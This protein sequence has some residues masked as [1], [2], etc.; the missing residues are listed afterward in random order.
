MLPISVLQTGFINPLEDVI[1]VPVLFVG[2]V[3]VLVT[4]GHLV[5]ACLDRWTNVELDDDSVDQD[6]GRLIG[7]CENILVITLV[8]AGAYTALGL[9]FAAKSFIRRDDTTSGDTTYY[10]AGTLVNFTYSL[11][12]GVLL[13]MV[14]H[15]LV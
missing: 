5:R 10:L 15:L 12:A 11:G 4:S 6:T 13:T 3:M 7:K 9:I 8:L 2:Y 14:I 1:T